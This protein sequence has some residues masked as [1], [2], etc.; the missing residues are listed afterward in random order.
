MDSHSKSIIGLV[1]ATL[2]ATALHAVSDIEEAAHIT[3]H[4]PP[5]TVDQVDPNRYI[6]TWY[7]QA[8][9]PYYFERGC[10]DTEAVYSL[11]DSKT[12][13]VDNTCYRDGKKVEAVGKAYVEDASYAKLKVVFSPIIPIGAQYW[14]V[15]LGD[16]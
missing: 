12:I 15:K 5:K 10:T 9:I 7:E 13:R 2:V 16:A 11:I 6:G 1:A 8:V 3:T 4:N 14:I